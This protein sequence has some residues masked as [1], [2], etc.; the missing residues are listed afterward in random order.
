[1]AGLPSGDPTLRRLEDVWKQL[2]HET[3][4]R[5]LSG[6]A[7]AAARLARLP[8]AH[9]PYNELHLKCHTWEISG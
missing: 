1:V 7:H 3:R 8:K 6:R 9:Q 4:R 5:L 2:H